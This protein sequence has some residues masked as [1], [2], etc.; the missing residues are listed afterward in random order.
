M[1]NISK[2]VMRIIG[3]IDVKEDYGDSEIRLMM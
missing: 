3:C 1:Q 2:M